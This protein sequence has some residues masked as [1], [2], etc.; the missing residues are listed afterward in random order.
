MASLRF[1]LRERPG[2]AISSSSTLEA[3][4]LTPIQTEAQS[5]LTVRMHVKCDC[6][7]GVARGLCSQHRE[8]VY[9]SDF[10]G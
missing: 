2:Q 3:V 5:R 1:Q 10:R 4:P 9:G 8:V 6:V 7:C